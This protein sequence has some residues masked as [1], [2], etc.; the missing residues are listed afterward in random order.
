MKHGPLLPAGGLPDFRCAALMQRG[1]KIVICEPA[2]ALR[3]P[4]S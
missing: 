4:P 2:D 1:F 3:V